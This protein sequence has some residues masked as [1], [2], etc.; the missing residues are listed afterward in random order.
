MVVI[1]KVS[2]PSGSPTGAGFSLEPQ[3]REV[4]DRWLGDPAILHDITRPLNIELL[5]EAF[6]I[7]QMVKS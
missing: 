5:G 6:L 2:P 3:A 7:S 1:E 4:I